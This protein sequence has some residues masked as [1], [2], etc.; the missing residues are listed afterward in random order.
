MPTTRPGL[1]TCTKAQLSVLQEALW[2]V[3]REELIF[4]A[5]A[6]NN[7]TLLKDLGSAERANWYEGRRAEDP[8]FSNPYWRDK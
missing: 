1:R 4:A 5:G 3:T 2:G 7:R 6:L 8:E